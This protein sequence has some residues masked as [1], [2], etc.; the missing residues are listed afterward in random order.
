MFN[1]LMQNDFIENQIQKGFTLNICGT[2]ENTSFMSHVIDKA[3]IEQRSLL[4]TLLDLEN[5][6]G[7]VDHN[8]ANLYC[9]TI[10]CLPMHRP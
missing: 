9:R 7:E 10:A 2:I 1:F 3:R 6:Y 4:I 5:A 8:L